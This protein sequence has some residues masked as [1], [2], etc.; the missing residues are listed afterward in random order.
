MQQNC[1]YTRNCDL[2]K[3]VKNNRYTLSLTQQPI[4]LKSIKMIQEIKNC[5]GVYQDKKTTHSMFFF[6]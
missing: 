3:T 1:I 5:R 6:Y 2:K 4:F